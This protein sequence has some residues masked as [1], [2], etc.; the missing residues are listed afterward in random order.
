MLAK[1]KRKESD[2]PATP[3]KKK[4][5]FVMSDAAFFAG[6]SAI[7]A[8]FLL[9]VVYLLR[10]QTVAGGSN[11]VMRMDLYHQYGPLYAEL[12]DRITS[13]ESLIYSWN[14]GLGSSFLGNFFNYCCSPFTLLIL[15]FGHINIPEAI[16]II[17]L[18]KAASAAACF[19]YF[20][21]RVFGTRKVSIAFGLLYAFCGYFVAY[22]W[23]VMWLDAFLIFPLVMLGIVFII[24]RGQFALYLAAMTYTMIT[25]YYMAYMVC[26]LSVIYFLYYYLSHYKLSD[27]L[28]KKQ[29]TTDENGVQTETGSGY[30]NDLR[31]SR[32]FM[33][34]VQFALT[35]ILAFLLAAFA[36][37]PVYFILKGSSATSS[38]GLPDMKDWKEYFNIFD[39]LANHLAHFNPTIRSSGTDVL[40]N[41]YS[42]LLTVLLV[43]AFL[44]CPSVS[45]RRKA[46][47]IGLLGLFFASFNLNFLNFIWHGFHYPNDLP[48]RFSFA[49]SFIILCLAYE[50]FLHIKEFSEKFFLT[51]G[52]GF[53]GFIVLV[54]ELGTKN[55]QPYSLL[56]SI[57]FVIIYTAVLI[58]ISQEKFKR[59][60]VSMILVCLVLA[61][62][63]CSNTT[64]YVMSQSKEAYT[65]D[66]KAFR[67]IS[68]IAEQYENTI[69][70][71][72]L[73]YREERSKLLTR[74]DASW[75]DYNGISVFSSMAYETTAK[76]HRHLGLFSNGINSYTYNPQ[77]A[78]YNSLFGIK[79]IYDEDDLI[80]TGTMYTLIGSTADRSFDAYE[81]NYYLPLA[82]SVDANMSTWADTGDS[83]PF[84][85]QNLLFELATGIADTLENVV[86]DASVSTTGG[87]YIADSAL[88]NGNFKYTASATS[89][90]TATITFTATQP[91]EHCIYFKSGDCQGYNI[92]ADNGFQT[93]TRY[94][95]G[96][97]VYYSVNVG[98]LDVGQS[99]KVILTYPKGNDSGT[100]HIY[101]ARL[102]LEKF[103][104]GYNKL[105]SNGTL[106]ITTF[107]ETFIE[108]RINVTNENSLL[109]TSI[110]YDKSWQVTIDGQ[111]VAEE[112]IISIADALLCVR[113]NPGVHTVSLRYEPQGLKLGTALTIIGILIVLLLVALWLINKK[114]LLA[115][116]GKIAFFETQFD[117]SLHTFEIPADATVNNDTS[118]PY[119][120]TSVF[121]H[122]VLSYLTCGIFYFVWKA[123][124][125]KALSAIKEEFADSKES[126]I[127]A[128]L[129]IPVYAPCW[130]GSRSK[131]L[132]TIAESYGIS[133]EGSSVWRTLLA[134]FGGGFFALA[135]LEDDIN[136]F[137]KHIREAQEI[138]ENEE[139]ISFDELTVEEEEEEI[140]D[141]PVSDE[142]ETAVDSEKAS[143]P[144]FRF[145]KR[146]PAYQPIISVLL[147]VV[148]AFV[149]YAGLCIIGNQ[150]SD[151]EPTTV[152][153]TVPTTIATTK[154]ASSEVQS[155][156]SYSSGVSQTQTTTETT[157]ETTTTTT[158]QPATTL[159]NND[160]M[161][162]AARMLLKFTGVELNDENSIIILVSATAKNGENLK[163]LCDRHGVDASTFAELLTKINNVKSITTSLK[164]GTTV[165]IPMIVDAE[166]DTSS[167]G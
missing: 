44:F 12:Y 146:T 78:I 130:I 37:L 111:P 132:K 155:D 159:L 39:F 164:A 26:I 4:Q 101:A 87:V 56:L 62:L 43:P 19:T 57:A 93:S 141:N 114:R 28:V 32:F 92:T 17:I 144:K 99:V 52:I 24:R 34:G 66:Y 89:E 152:S 118:R 5:K 137:Y 65:G 51:S 63:L 133:L 83:N 71:N 13:G 73:F 76:M 112:D 97:T 119:K 6:I 7:L 163:T 59:D 67:E 123:K 9:Y 104:E 102:N 117:K 160:V 134:V 54:Q 82:F 167:V 95:S 48:Y 110:P 75:M 150:L 81:Y 15:L 162:E 151:D 42:G 49:Y 86:A 64:N 157:T 29:E 20:I 128:F 38:S 109:Y 139:F 58:C 165:I 84:V 72:E 106:D 142:N 148:L 125:H 156:S 33:A 74:M 166:A 90:G 100:A 80:D 147:V 129:F 115:G 3:L 149:Y 116:K 131:Q 158:T 126:N 140:A 16:A 98:N 121:L 122:I 103:E 124:V 79:Y 53:L 68:E 35:S 46:L 70:D 127:L 143:T 107:E 135:E 88:S 40:P 108:G 47:S 31:N 105:L 120:Q 27:K 36:L 50:A 96:S 136:Y 113:I 94:S 138:K 55:K 77:T 11:T 154:V 1:F 41:I 30:L 2:I 69:G 25:N 85:N 45:K 60:T 8:I 10:L 18:L 14:T 23:N 153:T 61:E 21:N 161:A 91:G 22:S 145:I